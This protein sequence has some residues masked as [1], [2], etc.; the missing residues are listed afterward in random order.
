MT[1]PEVVLN[2]SC[3]VPVLVLCQVPEIQDF[4]SN[5]VEKLG[6]HRLLTRR[7]LEGWGVD[8]VSI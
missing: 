4:S 5:H 7:C 6:H 3:L 1:A 2:Q 8:A